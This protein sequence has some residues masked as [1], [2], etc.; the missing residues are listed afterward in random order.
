MNTGVFVAENEEAKMQLELRVYIH[1]KRRND[2][3]VE[4]QQEKGLG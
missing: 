3:F 1:F 2:K 4:K